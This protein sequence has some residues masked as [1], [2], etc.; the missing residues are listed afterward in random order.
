MTGAKPASWAIR[1]PALPLELPM[2]RI[3]SWLGLVLVLAAG[4]SSANIIYTL[5]GVTFDDG[6]TLTGT[7]TTNDAMTAL[8]DFNITTSAGTGIGFNYTPGS[9]DSTST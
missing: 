5:S 8:L 7:F 4:Q 6:G 2:K 9:A 1:H 3:L